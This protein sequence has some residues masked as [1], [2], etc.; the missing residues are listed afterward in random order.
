VLRF[1]LGFFLRDLCA[2]CLPCQTVQTCVL[3]ETV[4]E[5]SSLHSLSLSCNSAFAETWGTTTSQAFHMI[6][7]MDS[8]VLCLNLCK[9]PL[10]LA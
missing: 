3:L 6:F 10:L 7:S 4:F 8:T 9:C 5:I 1:D 2:H